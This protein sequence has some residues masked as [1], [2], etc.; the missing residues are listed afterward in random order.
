MRQYEN[1]LDQQNARKKNQQRSQLAVTKVK[2]QPEITPENR[3]NEA[4]SVTLD[5]L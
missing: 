3:S 2:R 1:V 5:L 4:S